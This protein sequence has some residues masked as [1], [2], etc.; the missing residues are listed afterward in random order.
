MC[1]PIRLLSLL[2]GT[3]VSDKKSHMWGSKTGGS[4][5]SPLA[6]WDQSTVSSELPDSEKESSP[7]TG[8]IRSTISVVSSELLDGEG[9]ST[10]STC[11]DQST[12]LRLVSGLESQLI[13]LKVTHCSDCTG[14]G[15]SVFLLGCTGLDESVHLLG[16]TWLGEDP[17]NP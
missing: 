17:S 14:L 12:D 9:E 7:S 2:P 1:R 10:Y 8:C 15:E 11:H 13:F 3:S 16:H 4:P 5:R 6:G